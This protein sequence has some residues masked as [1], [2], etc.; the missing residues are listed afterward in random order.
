MKKFYNLGK[1]IFLLLTL[2]AFSY[3]AQAQNAIW[4]GMGDGITW[5][6]GDNWDIDTPPAPG[7]NAIFTS[8][9]ANIT[10]TS[11]ATIDLL[12]IRDGRTVTLNI[13][14]NTL[15]VTSTKSNLVQINGGS[16][17]EVASGT[18][19]VTAASNRDAIQ[20]RNT[21]G[22]F[23]VGA[24]ATVNITGSKGFASRG[25]P[26]TPS[27]AVNNSGVINIG[28]VVNQDGIA[29]NSATQL[30]LVN[31][32]CAVINLGTSRIKTVVDGFSNITNNGLFTYEGT[33]SSGGIL[34]RAGTGS[35]TATNNGFYDYTNGAD[36]ATGN[37][38]I[39][40]LVDNGVALNPAVSID[41]GT[42]CVI[43]LTSTAAANMV[44]YDWAFGGTTFAANDGGGLL[45]LTD[46]DFPNEA[47]PH[48]ITVAGCP[49]YS[50]SIEV[51]NTCALSVLPVELISFTG[52]ERGTVNILEWATASELN[53]DFFE[54]QRSTNG[55]DFETIES[56]KGNGTLNTVS[57]YRFIDEK[58]ATVCYYR[59]QQV[60][61]D[62]KSELSNIVTIKRDLLKDDAK[63]FPSPVKDVLTINYQATA[64]KELTM[65][66]IDMTGRVLISKLVDAVEGSNEFNLDLVNLPTGTYMTRLNSG[67]DNISQ[68]IIKL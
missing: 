28:T 48:T 38:G 55:R 43:D 42:N 40:T 25:N 18:L 2:M 44:A 41:A 31:E 52:K 53:N 14:A 66:V 34:L 35:N 59:L 19:N 65:S 46:A 22:S 4:N 24:G 51:T 47:G 16:T 9:D 68:L 56:V 30:T 58:P 50:I 26:V 54:V 37:S 29:L 5:S 45:D 33:G 8:T 64:N 27:A 21:G 3:S 60:D 63:L 57:N 6:D 32:E 17:L 39:G 11:S 12:D 15:T 10:F 1:G 62:G 36:F 7:G 20:F 13:G 49:E 67:T 61:F 23:D